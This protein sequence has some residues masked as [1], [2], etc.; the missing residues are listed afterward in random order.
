MRVPRMLAASARPVPLWLVQQVAAR[1][2]ATVLARNP[3][4]FDRLGDYADSRYGFAPC[5]LPYFFEILPVVP[6][7]KV[8][9]AVPADRPDAVI[10]GPFFMLLG[11]LEGRIDGDAVFFSRQLSVSGDTEA[12]LA[13]RNALDDSALDL[14]A[15]IAGLAGPLARPVKRLLEQARSRLLP[16]SDVTW[17]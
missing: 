4:L 16:G 2:F 6:S 13:L 7:I 1:I 8:T 17:N 11:L 14:P 3:S 10:K 15:E 5:D 9:R 12:I